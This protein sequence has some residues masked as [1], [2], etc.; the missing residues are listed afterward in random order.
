MSNNFL[1]TQGLNM[2]TQDMTTQNINTF[3][4]FIKSLY[5]ETTSADIA[6]VPSKLGEPAA[7]VQ[8]RP[9]VI[10]KTKSP[11]AEDAEEIGDEDDGKT[12]DNIKKDILDAVKKKTDNPH[13]ASK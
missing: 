3:S 7:K 12:Q 10:N 5:E 6:R 2:K 4:D 1:K 11:D 9:S 8:K 13:K